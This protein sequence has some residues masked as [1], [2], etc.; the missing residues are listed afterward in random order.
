MKKRELTDRQKKFLEVLFEEANGD[1]VKAKMIAGYSE[2]SSTSSIVGVFCWSR[3]GSVRKFWFGSGWAERAGSVKFEGAGSEG[4]SLY[5]GLGLKVHLLHAQS[6][7]HARRLN[8]GLLK[9]ENR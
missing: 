7:C 8:K 4:F 9:A 5:M 6:A 2:H 1:P 3:V